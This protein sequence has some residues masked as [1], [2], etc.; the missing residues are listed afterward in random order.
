MQGSK[1]TYRQRFRGSR[2]LVVLAAV[3]A[4]LMPVYATSAD[5]IIVMV[6]H[7]A[8]VMEIAGLEFRRGDI[9]EYNVTTDEA[10]LKVDSEDIFKSRATLDAIFAKAY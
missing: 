1:R 7:R 2:C 9:I 4:L 5:D 3:S 10:V 8:G 6:C